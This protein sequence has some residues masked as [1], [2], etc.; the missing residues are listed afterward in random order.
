MQEIS[1]SDSRIIIDMFPLESI[2]SIR[3]SLEYAK[4]LRALRGKVARQKIAEKIQASG[5]KMAPQQLQSAEEG[6]IKNLPIEH[7]IA[8]CNVYQV[9]FSAIIPTIRIALPEPLG[10]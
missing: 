7:F 2:G 10:E 6:R 4:R 3:W 1:I 8:L 5:T 9:S